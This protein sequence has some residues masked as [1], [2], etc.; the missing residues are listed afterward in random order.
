M[1][2]KRGNNGSILKLSRI[3]ANINKGSYLRHFFRW[4]IAVIYHVI[5]FKT[6]CNSIQ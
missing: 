1:L 2:Q 3:L 5:L 4:D 6:R